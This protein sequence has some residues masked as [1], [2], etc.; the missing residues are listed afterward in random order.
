MLDI[1]TQVR[2]VWN[3]DIRPLADDAFRAYSGGALRASIAM[4]WAAVCADLIAK[5]SYLAED[6]D[7]KAKEYSA[8]VQA[9][10]TAGLTRDGV[11]KMQEVERTILDKSVEL[12]LIDTITSQEL[13]RIREDR[14]LCVHPSLRPLGEAYEPRPEV[15]RAHLAV[16]LDS[17]LVHPP[18]Q[19]RK[20]L[21]TFKEHLAD[22][23]FVASESHLLA[24][25][26][27]RVR[28]NTK[29]EII[30]LAAKHALLELPAPDPMAADTLA[31]R[32]AMCLV[33]FASRERIGV[34]QALTGLW[35]KFLTLENDRLLRAVAR[36]GH[37]DEFWDIVDAAMA[38]KVNLLLPG[39][40]VREPN[41]YGYRGVTTTFRAGG[42]TVLA[43]VR[44]RRA[45][46]K[47]ADLES[48]FNALPMALKWQVMAGCP[49]PYFTVLIAGLVAEVGSWRSA[50][51]L[52]EGVVIPH[53][54]WFTTAELR[55]VMEAWAGNTECTQASGM[56]DLAFQLYERTCHLP[57]SHVVWREF[58]TAVGGRVSPDDPA[59]K[60]YQYADLEA[61]LNPGTGPLDSALFA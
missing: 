42:H 53:A 27:D 46:E 10:Q 11:S 32:M 47:L 22:P 8:K 36:L 24:A 26:F 19:G 50:E 2:Q 12:E 38:E 60:W 18:I 48:Q 41:K 13:G 28:S 29:R 58:L 17:L 43:L 45:R 16:A 7:G 6:G 61:A 56:P 25:F 52:T 33:A 39:L 5:I 14:H 40:I 51:S 30:N 21:A 3:P 15:A 37:L 44:V 1:E 49:D 54:K 59:Y 9:A 57:G 31:D 34:Q 4:T 23:H 55:A 20:L 35:E